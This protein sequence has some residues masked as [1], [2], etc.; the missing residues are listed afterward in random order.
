MHQIIYFILHF[1]KN[2]N[3]LKLLTVLDPLKPQLD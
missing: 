3:F 1:I 2:I